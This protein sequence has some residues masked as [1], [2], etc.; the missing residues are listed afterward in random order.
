[1]AKGTW[2]VLGVLG[3]LLLIVFGALASF[4]G[5]YNSLN[6]ESKAVDAQSKQV[7]VQYQRAFGLLP[8]VENITDRYMQ[9]EKDI[10]TQVAALRSGY[11]PAINGSLQAKDN[12]TA[13]LSNL[14]LA[15]GNRAENYPDLKASD[16]YANLQV[17][18]T[19]TYNKIAAEK[20]RYN[21]DVQRYETHRTSCCVPLI[22]ANMFGFHEKPYIGYNNRPDQTSFP[23]GQQL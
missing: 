16:L 17:L 5:A 18:V 13:Q 11:G 15:V 4:V 22:V 7:D 23:A 1:M 21:D 8:Q 6:S 10:Q 3:A 20:V 14:I 9:N 2:I 19:D 12:Y